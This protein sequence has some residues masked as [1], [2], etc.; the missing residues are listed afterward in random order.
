[1]ARKV[2]RGPCLLAAAGPPPDR[3]RPATRLQAAGRRPRRRPPPAA[4]LRP[5]PGR[6]LAVV[7]RPAGDSQPPA[8]RRREEQPTAGPCWRSAKPSPSR[9]SAATG[10]SPG[11]CSTTPAS[12]PCRGASSRLTIYQVTYCGWSEQMQRLPRP[13]ESVVLRAGLMDDLIADARR[14][15]DG[16][17]LVR[18]ARHSLPPRLPAARPAGHRQKLGRRGDRL[19]PGD[20][21][22]RAE[23]QQR[24]RWTTTN[25]P[26]GWPMFRPTRSC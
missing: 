25:W 20:G 16:R 4:S 14:F 12:M 7:S 19:G 2:A 11:N 15:L 6:A 8:G 21:H 18:A 1:M 3:P 5:R 24:R 17:E 10:G 13:P 22:R 26:T 23:P 9:S